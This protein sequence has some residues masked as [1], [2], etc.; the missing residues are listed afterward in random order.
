MYPGQ[1]A[2]DFSATAL[3]G[4]EFK[5]S[6]LRGKT[7]LLDFWATWCGPCVGELPTLKQAQEKFADRGLVIVSISL[8]NQAETARKFA[9]QQGMNWTQLWTA[10][11]YESELA[12]LYGVGAIP[13][14][15]LIGPDGKVVARDLRGKK[16][17]RQI[18]K[19]AQPVAAEKP[20]GP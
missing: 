2:P 13:A 9:S 11:V 4:K 5:L 1:V 6:G 17:L 8:D 14:T 16:L 18:E 7:V 3:D 10:G 20:A 15:F 19:L 12:K